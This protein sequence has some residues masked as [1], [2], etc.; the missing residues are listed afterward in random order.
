M[1]ELED[2]RWL[3]SEAGAEAMRQ[4]AESL[5]ANGLVATTARLRKRFSPERTHLVLEQ[6]ELRRRAARKFE[7]AAHMFFA[8]VALQQATGEVVARYKA[9]RFPE[10]E[11]VFDLCCGIGGDLFALAARGPAVGIE[12]DAVVSLL[13]AA[14]CQVLGRTSA[15]VRTADVSTLTSEIE[16]GEIRLIHIDPDRR[17]HGKRTTR[18]ESYE[19]NE[20]FLTTLMEHCAGGAIKLAPAAAIPP[21]WAEVA[22]LEWLS[23]DGECKQ[24]IAWFGALAKYPAQRAAT[25]LPSEGAPHSLRGDDVLD[26]SVPIAESIGR[27]VYEADPAVIAARL[28]PKLALH[29]GLKRLAPRIAYL[30]GDAMTASPLLWAFEVI[31]ES[32]LDMKR[33]KAMLKRHRVGRLEIKKRGVEVSIEKLHRQ[34][35]TAGDETAALIITPRSGGGTTAILTRRLGAP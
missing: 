2:Y 35:Q 5:Q 6:I 12:R 22:E 30:T 10:D 20:A 1:A 23:H 8:P 28:V 19:P 4:A 3:T 17:P 18:V 26:S 32:P 7:D 13:A 15:E 29:H 14:N 33:V 16:R 27:Y 9:A 11:N 21:A 24:L 25:V 34:L 31:D